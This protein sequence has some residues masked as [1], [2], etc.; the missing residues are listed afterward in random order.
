MS[1]H[2]KN[3]KIKITTTLEEVAIGALKYVNEHCELTETGKIAVNA[4]LRLADI[5]EYQTRMNLPTKPI[6]ES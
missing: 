6:K 2:G 5:D 4:A 1:E 3:E